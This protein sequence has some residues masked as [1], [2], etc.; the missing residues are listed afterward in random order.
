MK[1]VLVGMSGGVDS[2][3]CAYLLK[4]QGYEVIGLTLKLYTN[5]SKCCN[6]DDIH[7][8]KMVASRLEIP[9]YVM[10]IQE[11]FKDKV[12][13]YFIDSY[14]AG[15]TPNPCPFCNDQ[16]KLRMMISKADELGIDF[17][18]SGHY[19]K[20]VSTSSG[21][22]LQKAKDSR[23]SQ[24][25][26]LALVS[27]KILSRLLLPLSEYN[28]SEI[29]QIAQNA[30]LC[31]VS[32]KKDSQEV[33]FI[34]NGNYFEFIQDYTGKKASLGEIW[35]SDGKMVGTHQGFYKYTIGQRR[36][37]GVGIGKPQYVVDIDSEN[38]RVIIGDK[39]LVYKNK[40]TIRLDRI[41]ENIKDYHPLSVKIR[42]KS[43]EQE[44]RI[45]SQDHDN[46]QIEAIDSFHA[47]TP[48][49]LAVFY[50]KQGTVLASGEIL[51]AEN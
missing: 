5:A 21:F 35:T 18:A 6:L 4:K 16:V 31:N 30:G 14:L 41:F 26:F 28:K 37:I 20:I 49:Q 17:I 51:S 42:Y 29:R 2:S 44:C 9:H 38:N 39:E 12:I 19:A 46:V 15:K 25:Y 3:V 11:I 36:G 22:R 33:C 45:I 13:Q 8:A 7:D 24:E 10:D 40:M 47:V 1:K 43:K 50:D 27:E 23:K 32:E 34:P 48:G